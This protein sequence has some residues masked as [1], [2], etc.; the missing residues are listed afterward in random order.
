MK[1][2]QV[3]TPAPVSVNSDE[4]VTTAAQVMKEY[5]IGAIVVLT[6]RKITGILTD[7]DIAVR[8]LAARRDPA[9]TLVRDVATADP[10]TLDMDDDTGEAVRVMRERAIRRLPVTDGGAPV[11]MISIGDLALA[12]DERSAL[13]EVSAAPPNL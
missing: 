4:P 6:D 2:S 5:S 12:Q 10:V 1:I 7:R 11:G 13:A 9:L 8:V 3:M